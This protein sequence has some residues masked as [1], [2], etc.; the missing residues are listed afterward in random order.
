MSTY[1]RKTRLYVFICGEELG[2]RQR[3]ET[4]LQILDSGM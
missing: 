2:V 1:Y 4:A 3:L